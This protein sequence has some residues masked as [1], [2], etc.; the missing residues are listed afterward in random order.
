MVLNVVVL[1]NR[2]DV[3]RGPGLENDGVY[4]VCEDGRLDFEGGRVCY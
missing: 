4:G 1:L 2:E 3:S